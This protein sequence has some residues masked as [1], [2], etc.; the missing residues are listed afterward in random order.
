MSLCFLLRSRFDLCK[1]KDLRNYEK[2][3]FSSHFPT[4][5]ETSSSARLLMQQKEKNEGLFVGDY[6]NIMI[7]SPRFWHSSQLKVTRDAL[8]TMASV[9]IS[10]VHETKSISHM[11][12]CGPLFQS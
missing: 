3:F 2:F 1:K 7:H 11:A 10:S 5:Y 9:D 12:D 4:F 8:P 6:G